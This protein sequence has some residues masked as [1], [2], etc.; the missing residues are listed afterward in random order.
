M[1][2]ITATQLSPSTAFRIDRGPVTTVLFAL[3]LGT[4]AIGT[5]V[6]LRQAAL[7]LIGSFLGIALYHGSFGF[8]G[9]WRR[10]V[11]ER[12]G[13]AIRAQMLMIAVAALAFIPLLAR[14]EAFGH[15]LVG[16]VAPVGV[17]SSSARR[18]SASTCSS[19]AD[20]VQPRSSL[21][22]AVPRACW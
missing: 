20:A 3:L 8:T 7:F 16:A 2:D 4:I 6:D 22:A 19:A 1:A 5:L 18:C 10:F 15:L 12:R 13:R 9:G 11:V 17:S 14:G 21:S